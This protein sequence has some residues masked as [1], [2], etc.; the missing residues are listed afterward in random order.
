M[1]CKIKQYISIDK[2]QQYNLLEV[3]RRGNL[4]EKIAAVRQFHFS[5]SIFWNSYCD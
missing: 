3:I 2:N 5:A 4:D 1:K